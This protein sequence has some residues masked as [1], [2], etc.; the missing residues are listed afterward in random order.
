MDRN[1]RSDL[2]KTSFFARDDRWQ[3]LI[4]EGQCTKA[5][6]ASER[7]LKVGCRVRVRVEARN[8]GGQTKRLSQ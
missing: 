5:D 7:R 6:R 2:R 8:A 4:E 3:L 1:S